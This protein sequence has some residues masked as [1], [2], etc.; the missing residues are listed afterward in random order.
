M[1]LTLLLS[2]ALVTFLSRRESDTLALGQRDESLGSLADDED[3][4]QSVRVKG[5][6]N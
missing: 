5:K 3:V 2:N 6:E 1:D 4:V